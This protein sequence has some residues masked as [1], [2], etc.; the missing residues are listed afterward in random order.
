V[1]RARLHARRWSLLAVALCS[2]LLALAPDASGAGTTRFPESL[3]GVRADAD[4]I[5]RGRIV[6]AK[7]REVI[8]RGVN[9]NALAEYW[10]GN[11]FPVTFP[12]T[13]SDV[14][15]MR[16]VGWNSVRLLLSWSRIEPEPGVYDESYI[17]QATAM[18][19]RLRRAG[20]YTIIDLHQDRW[21]AH[22]AG[23]PDEICPPGWSPALGW[24]G[25]P[26]WATL[27][28][29]ELARC[30]RELAR[31][32]PAV[33]HAW[34]AFWADQPGP[35]DVGIR[36][37]YISM[38]R[39]LAT[40]FVRTDAVAGFD[41]MNEPGVSGPQME[42][43]DDFSSDALQAIREA[44]QATGAPSRMVLIEPA[45]PRP[46]GEGPPLIQQ[47]QNVAYAPHPYAGGL[48]GKPFD[49][50]HPRPHD[51]RGEG[52]LRRAGHRR[53]V[54]S[55]PVAGPRGLLRRAPRPPGQAPDE[56]DALAV[57]G[58]LRR[59]PRRGAQPRRRQRQ[60]LGPVRDGLRDQ[61]GERHAGRPARRADAPVRAR[62]PGDAARAALRGARRALH[63]GRAGAA[64]QPRDAARLLAGVQARRAADPRRRHGPGAHHAHARRRDARARRPARALVAHA[65]RASLTGPSTGR[66]R[67]RRAGMAGGW[68]A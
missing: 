38:L 44:E 60:R 50:G 49:S 55:G 12:L 47:G 22:I 29:P 34:S 8:L 52:P 64:Q 10:R 63:R 53:R 5:K 65:E 3:P 20:M 26:A 7:G 33:G 66:L 58:Q 62:R 42:A 15:V 1:V 59:S 27:V 40:R 13:H 67:A 23:R 36:T 31:W 24:D 21:G 37:R 2:G 19:E 51:H 16:A 30:G 32:S 6:D 25:A 14:R 39:H 41:I 68:N 46:P 4:G 28:P 45:T 35:G 18:V 61:R 11:A 17:A 54:G 48:S 9:V 56:L 57:P 43:F